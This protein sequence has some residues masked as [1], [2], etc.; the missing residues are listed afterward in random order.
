MIRNEKQKLFFINGKKRVGILKNALFPFIFW[1]PVR[2][3][4]RRRNRADLRGKL[5]KL[6]LVADKYYHFKRPHLNIKF[7]A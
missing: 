5:M 7:L 1:S 3:Y 6:V 2:P 4:I